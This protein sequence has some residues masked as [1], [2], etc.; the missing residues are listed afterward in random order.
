MFL[1]VLVYA[2]A[3]ALFVANWQNHGLWL[4]L[5]ILFTARALTLAAA[6]PRLERSV[7]GD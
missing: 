4:A 1:S 7:S 6:Y 3:V 5:M 2:G